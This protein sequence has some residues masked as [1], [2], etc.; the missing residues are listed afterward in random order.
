MG[1]HG[2]VVLIEFWTFACY[3]C[4]NAL[5]SIKKWDAQYRDKG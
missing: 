5:P 2:R 4:R 1:L 3:N